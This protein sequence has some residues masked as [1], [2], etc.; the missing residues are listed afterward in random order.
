MWNE[1]SCTKL[2]LPPEPLTG[3]A[4]APRSSFSLSPTEFEPPPQ[5]NSWVRHCSSENTAQINLLVLWQYSCSRSVQV[6][7]ESI[8]YINCSFWGSTAWSTAGIC[9]GLTGSTNLWNFLKI[10]EN[11]KSYTIQNLGKQQ[12]PRLNRIGNTSRRCSWMLWWCHDP[13]Y[14]M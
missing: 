2:Q 7:F 5:Q 6:C 10:R 3:G 8:S 4:T 14:Q 11:W 9:S 13:Q 12:G 1:I